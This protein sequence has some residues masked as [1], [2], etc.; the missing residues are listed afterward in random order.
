MKRDTGVELAEF[1]SAPRQCPR[2]T[3][4]LRS[5]YCAHRSL[6]TTPARRGMILALTRRDTLP[7]ACGWEILQLPVLFALNTGISLATPFF[8][9]REILLLEVTENIIIYNLMSFYMY[10]NDGILCICK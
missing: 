9:L 1:C 7:F 6:G 4:N 2:A 10:F 8:S 5:D 3:Q